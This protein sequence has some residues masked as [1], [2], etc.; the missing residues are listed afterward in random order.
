MSGMHTGAHCNHGERCNDYDFGML[1][2]AIP[3]KIRHGVHDFVS[4][5]KFYLCSIFNTQYLVSCPSNRLR[6]T[7]L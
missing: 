2:F 1:F 4:R 5:L 7:L 3:L 6:S